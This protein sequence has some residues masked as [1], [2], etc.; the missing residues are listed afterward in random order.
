MRAE[1]VS[2]TSQIIPG[3]ADVSSTNSSNMYFYKQKT[4]VDTTYA[5]LTFTG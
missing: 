4:A 5:Y 1:L 2:K 3:A